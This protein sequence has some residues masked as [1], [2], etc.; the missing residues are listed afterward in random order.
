MN[1]KFIVLS[2][3]HWRARSLYI[4]QALVFCDCKD[5]S[6]CLSILIYS[7]SV[8]LLLVW[9]LLQVRLLSTSTD[10]LLL[11][12]DNFT[13]CLAFKMFSYFGCQKLSYDGSAD[14]NNHY[15]SLCRC[16][17]WN[18]GGILRINCCKDLQKTFSC[19]TPFYW[20]CTYAS[21]T[22]KWLWCKYWF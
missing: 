10:C 4:L 11:M 19:P 9:L 13:L 20:Y 1:K 16:C 12:L 17:S 6:V 15:W 14:E 22:C 8:F 5:T 18:I 2:I 21:Y 7:L 3:L